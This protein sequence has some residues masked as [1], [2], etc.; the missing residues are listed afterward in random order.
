MA[1][2]SPQVFNLC[3][4]GSLDTSNLSIRFSFCTYRTIRVVCKERMKEALH[5]EKEIEER[6]FNDFVSTFLD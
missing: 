3:P 5:D 6:R 2:F 1:P 4:L